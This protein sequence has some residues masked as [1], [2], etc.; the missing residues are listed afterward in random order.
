MTDYVKAWECIGCGRIEAPQPCIGVCQDRKVQF[1]YA[2]EHEEA[3]AYARIVEQKAD[4]L[5][6]LVRQ[7]ALTN[8]RNGEW[9]K[10]Y[11][12]MQMQA[13]RVLAN[14]TVA[15][16]SPRMDSVLMSERELQWVEVQPRNE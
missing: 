3:L 6:A 15:D 5:K 4:A 2:A 1:V 16:A 9:E 8:P 11:L 14:L 7:L 10:C 12:A 13:R